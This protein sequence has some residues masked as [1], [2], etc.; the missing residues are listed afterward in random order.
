MGIRAL[1]GI[2]VTSFGVPVV[3][4]QSECAG[5]NRIVPDVHA[6]ILPAT[7]TL[8]REMGRSAL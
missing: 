3:V 8:S 4:E 1:V 5:S 6:A 7:G 2:G